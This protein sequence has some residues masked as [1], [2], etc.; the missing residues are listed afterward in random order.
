V[1]MTIHG[2]APSGE[3]GATLASGCYSA[4]ATVAAPKAVSTPALT[5]FS[6][7]VTRGRRSHATARA[8]MKARTTS[9]AKPM[10]ASIAPRVS[11]VVNSEECGGTNCGTIARKNRP[12][13]GFSAHENS[14]EAGA[15]SGDGG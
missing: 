9:H 12:T 14:P 5:R 11:T 15:G 4:L 8:A 1:H 3:F 7:A 10:T 6:T 2:R 13:I